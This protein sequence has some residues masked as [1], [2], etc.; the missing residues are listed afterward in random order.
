[1]PDNGPNDAIVRQYESDYDHLFQQQVSRLQGWVRV[2]T[3]QTGNMSAFGLLGPSDVQEMSGQRHAMTDWSDDPSYRRWATKHDYIGAK[4]LD[5]EDRLEI[6]VDLEMGYAENLAMAMGRKMDKIVIDATTGTAASGAQGTGTS[7]YSTTEALIDGSGGNQIPALPTGGET[8]I[9]DKMRLARGIFIS[10]EVGN[11]DLMGGANTFIWLTDGAGHKKL[12]E[13]TEA[14]STDYLGVTIVNGAEATSR[15]P[16][17][18]GHIPFYM[19]FQIVLSNQLN[20]SG[21]S[22]VNL[23]WHKRAMGM[24]VWGGRRVWFGDLPEHR[25]S[26]GIIVKEHFGAVRVHDLGVLS[27]L[28]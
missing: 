23:A 15:M 21:A 8:T 5:E 26:R 11:E 13:N 24:A 12:L 9:I 22:H 17:V 2:K 20:T 25:L 6:L 1:M 19:G 14:T 28:I 16:L 7:T 18:S 3:G 4:M 10:R 27:I